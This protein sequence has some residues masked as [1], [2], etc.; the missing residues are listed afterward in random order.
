[1]D[2]LRKL[3]R[4][5]H[6]ATPKGNVPLFNRAFLET[7]KVFG[8]TYDIAMIA[9]YKVGTLKLMNDTEKFPSML[10]RKKI[11][12]LPSWSGDRKTV[13][14]IFKKAKERQEADR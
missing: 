7:V 9:A 13:R 4:E 3:A 8:R 14:R 1:M 12:L 5:K 11:S 2:A 10:R 6:A